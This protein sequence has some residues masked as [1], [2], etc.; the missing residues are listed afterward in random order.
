MQ[1]HPRIS[2]KARLWQGAASQMCV[3]VRS[4]S[5][6]SH[7]YAVN[8]CD[9]IKLFI[10]CQFRW[11]SFW[12]QPIPQL[13]FHVQRVSIAVSQAAEGGCSGVDRASESCCYS[14]TC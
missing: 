5:K 2:N 7:I 11:F 14:A 8:S 10:F 13:T 9:R 4:L 3:T 12:G 6:A 1:C